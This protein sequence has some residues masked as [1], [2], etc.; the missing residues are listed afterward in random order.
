MGAAAVTGPDPAAG[1]WP[2]EVAAEIAAPAAGSVWIDLPQ[3]PAA[4]AALVRA[5][6]AALL[7]Q[8]VNG[9]EILVLVPQRPRRSPEPPAG[10]GRAAVSPQIHTFYGLAARMVRLFWPRVAGE[11]GFRAPLDP[12][13]LLTY[14]TAQYVMKQIVDP[15]VEQGAFDGL[16]LRPQRLL[17]QL[18]D[19]LNK[20]GVNGYDIAEV[21]PRLRA[22]WTARGE[23]RESWF[24]QAQDCIE[25]YRAHCLENNLLDVSLALQI[26]HRSLLPRKEFQEHLGDRFRH[27]LVEAVEETV[28]LAQDFVRGRLAAADSAWLVARR[29]GGFRVFL[30]VDPE[31]ARSLRQDCGRRLRVPDEPVRPTVALGRA[32]SA[33]FETPAEDAAFEGEILPGVLRLISAR[34]RGRMVGEVAAEVVRLVAAGEAEP[35]EIAVVAPHADGVLRFLVAEA[36]REAEIPCAVV[37]RFE[38][39]REEPETRLALALAALAYP[40][41]RRPP[42]AADV[43]E[44]LQAA[45]ALDA[46]RAQLLTRA[47]Y[48][49][50]SGTLRDLG[51]GDERLRERLPDGALEAFDTLRRWLAARRQGEP[52]PLDL[53]LRQLFGEVLSRPDLD[54]ARAAMYSRLISSAAWF[55]RS[56]PSLGAGPDPGG[57]AEG[58]AR[59][60]EEGVVAAAHPPEAPA[61]GAVLVVAPVYTYLLEERF[62]RFQFWLDAGSISWWEPPHQ[63]L[64]NPHVLSRG[65]PRE[66]RWTEAVDFETRNRT[67]GRLVRGLCSRAGEAVYLCWSETEGGGP[68]EE[69]SPLLRA[70]AELAGPVEPAA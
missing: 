69:D 29:D 56:A 70:A 66:A 41:W 52:Q 8:G 9:D 33:R 36:L 7:E 16:S 58:Y 31:G 20:A 12:P 23:G 51:E 6:L 27:L 48:D 25:A 26:F 68:P 18:L 42:H 44:A 62:D 10:P 53:F 34:H 19:N 46:V 61:A 28:P 60:V 3:G 14:E 47:G 11:A 35:G 43:S 30:G 4:A 49:A 63:P 17:S 64:T 45:L 54:P 40:G 37:R 39:L 65:W 57:T 15:V 13:V 2:E 1:S 50:G 59:M 67:L 55:R 22:S 32:L 24:D 38:S 5:R 21:G